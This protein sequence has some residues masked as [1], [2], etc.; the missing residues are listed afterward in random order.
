MTILRTWV[1]GS[2]A[3]VEQPGETGAV[4]AIPRFEA[5]I[6]QPFEEVPADGTFSQTWKKRY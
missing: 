3:E 6:M 1:V 5:D 2:V 4:G